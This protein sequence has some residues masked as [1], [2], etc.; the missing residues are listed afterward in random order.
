VEGVPCMYNPLHFGLQ[1]V[2]YGISTHPNSKSGYLLTSQQ[3]SF[4]D[5]AASDIHL[6][7]LFLYGG[8]SP[9]MFLSGA[10]QSTEVV[11]S[12][13][14]YSPASRGR[15]GNPFVSLGLAHH[16]SNRTILAQIQNPRYSLTSRIS[17]PGYGTLTALLAPTPVTDPVS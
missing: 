12:C 11:E 10:Q 17:C 7:G 2:W 8:F 3:L 16:A 6:L 9:F 4:E 1:Q 14:G 13:W 15:A 5:D